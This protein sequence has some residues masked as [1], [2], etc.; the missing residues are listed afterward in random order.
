[1]GFYNSYQKRV[2]LYLKRDRFN[3]FFFY[4]YV[5]VMYMFIKV[6]LDF[7][8]QERVNS[9]LM[10]VILYRCGVFSLYKSFGI[11]DIGGIKW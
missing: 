1:M 11:D 9:I 3:V 7:M 6:C 2:Y 10:L 5:Y 4:F 8:F